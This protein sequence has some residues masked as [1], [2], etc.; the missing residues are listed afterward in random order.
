MD[1]DYRLLLVVVWISGFLLGG[2][3]LRLYQYL[4]E[5]RRLKLLLGPELLLAY[6]VRVKESHEAAP[7][8]KTDR[9]VVNTNNLKEAKDERKKLKANQHP[10][11]IA[12]RGVARG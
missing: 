7:D 11:Y 5:R 8:T 3:A 10:A 1:A 4:R 2:G 9:L 6:Q 12:Q